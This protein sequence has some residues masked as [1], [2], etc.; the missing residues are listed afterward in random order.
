MYMKYWRRK[1]IDQLHYTEVKLFVKMMKVSREWRGQKRIGNE[2]DEIPLKLPNHNKL[3]S[4][5]TYLT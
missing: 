4:I 5:R 3:F 1:Q 2:K